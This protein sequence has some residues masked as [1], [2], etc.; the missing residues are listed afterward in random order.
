ML[1][2]QFMIP[3]LLAWLLTGCALRGQAPVEEQSA[4][5]RLQ[6][7]CRA[8]FTAADQ[9][10]LA[11]GVMDSEAGRISGYPHLRVNRFLSSFRD[12][13]AGVGYGFWLRQLQG[14]ANTGWGLEIKNL[15]EPAGQT[16]QRTVQ[17][18]L[19]SQAT[20]I[21]ALHSCSD[22]LLQSQ[23]EA[24][25]SQDGLTQQA[26]VADNY[27]TW[28]RVVG[29]YPLTA[30]AFKIGI[31][32]W[33]A[34]TRSAFS[35]P[36][37]QLQVLGQLRRYEPSPGQ[38]LPDDTELSEIIHNAS[39]NPLKIPLPA[40]TEQARLFRRFAPLFEIDVATN[41][42]RLGSPELQADSP[43]RINTNTPTV[44]QHLSHTRLGDQILLQLNYTIWF[45]AR[46]KSSVFD[47]LGGQVDG[48]TWRV[49]LLADGRP[50]MFD[51]IHNCGCY[52][53]FF[54][55]QYAR[56]IQAESGFAESYFQPQPAL[57]IKADMQPVLRIAATTHYIERVYFGP[58]P[59]PRLIQYQV[60][61]A[62]RL[63]S[64]A[65]PD[66]S[67]RSLFGQDGLV[68]STER[69][70]RYLFWP[71]GILAPGAMRQWG[72]HATAFVGRRHFDDARL[73]EK[74]YEINFDA[75]AGD[76]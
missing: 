10:V 65:L 44:F 11:A 15:P 8:V 9:A 21:E 38:E 60:A 52:H 41:D 33:H 2:R 51:A 4:S 46:P 63:R 73:F 34:K 37:D 16:L 49:T 26:T 57:V 20:T 68:A 40:A 5:A 66:G 18:I 71:M 7:A 30:W 58:S 43:P 32:Q 56:A 36:L 28:E 67:S 76:R 1:T 6:T 14:L 19:A 3:V 22:T 27:E 69:S 29:L 31:A 35:Q 64:L 23:L 45:P 54:P 62:D 59:A 42:D 74:N 17:G 70:E 61:A 72:H 75:Q 39:K 25:G 13:V 48:I 47:L 55:T 50:W 24:P 53:L 12:E